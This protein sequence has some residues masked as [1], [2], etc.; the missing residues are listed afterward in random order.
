VVGID[1]TCLGDSAADGSEYII[2]RYSDQ[3]GGVY[4]RLA[5]REGKI[6]GAILLGD[7][8]DARWLQQLIAA[9]QD[10]SAYGGR[11]LDGGLDLKELAQGRLRS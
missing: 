11:L 4:K 6:V 10:V 9:G 2:L 3:S 1:L 8:Q 7:T 5:L